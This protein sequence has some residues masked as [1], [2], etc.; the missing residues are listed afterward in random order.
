[1]DD[2]SIPGTDVP[3][4]RRLA[5][6]QPTSNLHQPL[7]Q[8]ARHLTIA[9][10]TASARYRYGSG[11][12]GNC[13]VPATTTVTRLAGLLHWALD[14]GPYTGYV[15][16]T[17][18]QIPDITTQRLHTFFLLRTTIQ[19]PPSGS[20]YYTPQAEPPTAHPFPRTPRRLHVGI[21]STRARTHDR[22]KPAP[23]R[24]ELRAKSTNGVVRAWQNE[25]RQA[26][27]QSHSLQT[28]LQR[29]TAPV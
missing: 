19:L 22:P 12:V 25:H 21:I 11:L 1:M 18:H 15:A 16:R 26:I 8:V 28:T 9:H 29:P 3:R 14:T 2:K 10:K 5:R 24:F 7:V 13:W 4:S 20:R 23:A 17:A 27:S 6:P